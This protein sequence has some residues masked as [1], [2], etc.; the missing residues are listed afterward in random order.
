[1]QTSVEKKWKYED[2]LKLADDKRY[3]IVGGELFMIAASNTEHQDIV[4]YLFVRL[5]LF[6]KEKG[7]GKVFGA[8]TDVILS[9]ENTVQP[10][11]FFIAKDSL[12]I[13]ER[14]GIFGSP[15]LMIEVVSSSSVFY[16]TVEKKNLYED[17]GVKE[18]WHVFP[19]EK[20]IEVF[21]LKGD[22]YEEYQRVKKKGV[23]KSHLLAGIEIDLEEL[24][25][26]SFR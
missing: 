16:D 26:S 8:P 18:L 14:Q 6:V 23:I 5:Y 25:A 7:L 22:R 17:F 4:G 24:F 11:I 12:G 19:E 13:I 10:D 2:Y 9:E 20:A 21:V 1:M 3:K 15:D